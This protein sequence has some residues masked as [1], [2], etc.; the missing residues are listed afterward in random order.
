[1]KGGLTFR[2]LGLCVLAFALAF[3]AAAAAGRTCDGRNVVAPAAS[4]A[5]AASRVAP[6]VVSVLVIRP[7]ADTADDE[8]P[9]F[10][11]PMAGGSP[12]ALPD[13][14][15]RSFSS[16]FV[17]RAGEVIAS[18]HAVAAAQ[19]VWIVLADGRRFA[20]RVLGFDRRS[21]VAL[22]AVPADG[23]SPVA[24]ARER[25]CAGDWVAALG[26]PFGFE[27][28]VSA[29][30]VSAWPRVLP[31]SVTVPLIQTDVA[32]NPGSSGGPL[33]NAAGEVVGMNTMVYSDTGVYMGV[34]FAIPME[35]VLQAA[36]ELKSAGYVRRGTIGVR[37]Q[38][39]TPA[40][41]EAFGLP[42]ARGAL[43]AKVLDKGMARAAGLRP[44][45]VVTSLDGRRIGDQQEF[46]TAVDRAK[47]GQLLSLGIWR[48]R[49]RR[50]VVI[51]AEAE[52][53]DTPPAAGASDAPEEHR[54]GLMLLAPQLA[55]G[56]GPGVFVAS[57]SGSSVLAGLEP[58][59]R[60]TAVNGREVANAEDFDEALASTLNARSVALLVVRSGVPLYIPVRRLGR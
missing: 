36:A 39:V 6:A 50:D 7:H 46:E 9:A 5:Q 8:G 23:L 28:S 11:H 22:L 53:A 14:Q 37:T 59:D 54:L 10:F 55:R 19:G 25:V 26:A 40:L 13:G 52:A 41:A 43:V 12:A 38:P 57:A 60:I 24:V 16:G 31:G 58:G 15:E 20:A 21:D 49:S 44:G 3:G 29:G 35:T 1:M 32:L 33:F 48:D 56:H 18:A 45:D 51:V 2:T 17:L 30:V 27:Y 42:A 34:S 47:P 4:F